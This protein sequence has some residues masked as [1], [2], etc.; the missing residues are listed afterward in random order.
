[1]G[2]LSSPASPAAPASPYPLSAPVFV[3]TPPT[4]LLGADSIVQLNAFEVDGDNERL[5]AVVPNWKQVLRTNMTETGLPPA[6]VNREA[7]FNMDRAMEM[8]LR[9]IEKRNPG[10]GNCLALFN[11]I[12]ASVETPEQLP[13]LTAESATAEIRDIASFTIKCI[14]KNNTLR[15]APIKAAQLLSDYYDSLKFSEL[16]GAALAESEIDKKRESELVRLAFAP[17]LEAFPAT[18]M[19][20][21]TKKEGLSPG[22]RS[23]LDVFVPWFESYAKDTSADMHRHM[24]DSAPLKT[25]PKGD[26]KAPPSPPLDLRPDFKQSGTGARRDSKQPGKE[27]YP[28]SRTPPTAILDSEISKGEWERAIEL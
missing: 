27:G 1:L 22:R 23:R 10:A 12:I 13:Y 21:Y 15:N 16:L 7:F 6:F 11:A 14:S 9:L 25:D 19:A 3:Y 18:I 4:V 20:F 24:L 28:P 2:S 26:V 17:V 5:K 8:K